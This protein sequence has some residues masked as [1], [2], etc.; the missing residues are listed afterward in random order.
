MSYFHIYQKKYVAH[1]SYFTISHHYYRTEISSD[2]EWIFYPRSLR[3]LGLINCSHL[4]HM[5]VINNN[6][7]TRVVIFI[8]ICELI[9]IRYHNKWIYYI[10]IIH[11]LETGR[12]KLYTLIV[13]I[14]SFLSS[15]YN[16]KLI[17]REVEKLT[18]KSVHPNNGINFIQTSLNNESEVL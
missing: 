7:S 2:T 10:Y 1:L 15:V 16:F 14:M 4:A 6:C 11:L 3:P 18:V 5:A 9:S 17:F 12:K 13:F 8:F